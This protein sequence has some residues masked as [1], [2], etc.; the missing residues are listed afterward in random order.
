MRKGLIAATLLL[1][2]GT[3]FAQERSVRI[4]VGFAPGAGTD[5]LARL[6]ADRMRVT[7]GQPVI[8]ENKPGVSGIV[9]TEAA[10]ASPP[11][12]TTLILQPLAPMVAHPY[13]YAKLNYDPVR[14]FDPVAHLAEFQLAFAVGPQLG[15]H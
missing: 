13:T 1:L 6:V 11:N 8:V 7:L 14:D 12:G 3:A 4:L 10:K 2:A 5:L 9:A 15:V